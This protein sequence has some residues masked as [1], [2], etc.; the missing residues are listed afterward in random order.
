MVVGGIGFFQNGF[1]FYL[2]DFPYPGSIDNPFFTSSFETV[3]KSSESVNRAFHSRD[4]RLG[5]RYDEIKI[6]VCDFCVTGATTVDEG[7]HLCTRRIEIDGRC[8]DHDIGGNHFFE[9]FGGIVFL[10]T[11]LAVHATY[12]AACAVVYVFVF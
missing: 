2:S 9:H 1:P 10:R 7:F 6:F 5:G 4:T 12:T 8:H 11:R 3:E